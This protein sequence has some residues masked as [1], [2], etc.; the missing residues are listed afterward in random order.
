MPCIPNPNKRYG[1]TTDQLCGGADAGPRKAQFAADDGGGIRGVTLTG[2]ITY[3]SATAPSETVKLA[4]AETGS[5]PLPAL[6]REI[7]RVTGTRKIAFELLPANK[8]DEATHVLHVTTTESEG[9]TKLHAVLSDAQSQTP[10]K[11]WDALYGPGEWKYAA[12]ALAGVVSAG[13]H[14]TPLPESTTR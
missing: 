8:A 1:K 7:G 6:E 14:L 4:L 13:L 5:I 11:T 10:V 12:R 3:T 9:Q 2:V